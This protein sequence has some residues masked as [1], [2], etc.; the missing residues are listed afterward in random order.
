MD[1]FNSN[2]P[3][4]DSVVGWHEEVEGKNRWRMNMKSLEEI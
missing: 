1:E 3:G 2:T 4:S